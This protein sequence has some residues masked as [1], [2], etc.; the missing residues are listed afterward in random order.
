MHVVNRLTEECCSGL[1]QY[2]YNR[3]DVFSPM[4]ITLLRRA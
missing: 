2:S 4:R 3:R 1:P